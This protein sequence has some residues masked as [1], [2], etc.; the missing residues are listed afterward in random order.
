MD[1]TILPIGDSVGDLTSEL[2]VYG[3]EAIAT[4]FASTGPK[5]YS[6]RIET[7]VGTEYICKSKGLTLNRGNRDII[8]YNSMVEIVQDGITKEI[9][10][11]QFRTARFDGPIKKSVKK[12]LKMV[13]DKRKL[14]PNFETLPWG[15]KE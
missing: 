11:E 4:G 6:L 13:Y 9:T 8:N 3:P 1:E 12:T 10:A 14:L 2:T 7:N 15:Y 5:S